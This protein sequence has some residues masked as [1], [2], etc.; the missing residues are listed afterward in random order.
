MD[1]VSGVADLAR[2]P[3]RRDLFGLSRRRWILHVSVLAMMLLAPFVAIYLGIIDPTTIQNPGP[4]DGFALLLY[5]PELVLS[6]VMYLIFVFANPGTTAGL[7]DE[8]D[9]AYRRPQDPPHRHGH[10]LRWPAAEQS[11]SSRQNA[12]RQ[13]R[14]SQRTLGGGAADR[15]RTRLAEAALRGCDALDTPDAH[16]FGDLVFQPE[17]VGIKVGKR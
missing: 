1:R 15:I 9:R 6:T 5:Q 13:A 17:P 11:G 8:R 2:G 3:W 16:V 10:L 14:E 4:G 12:K 7:V